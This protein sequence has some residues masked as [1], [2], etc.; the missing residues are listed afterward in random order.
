VPVDFG[1]A[2]SDYARHRAGFPAA[3]FD[4]L[5]RGGVV[6]PG[7]RLL[8]LGTGT[9]SL[10]RGFARRGLQVT[11]LDPARPLLDQARQ[12][13][14]AAGVAVAYVLARAESTGLA[15]ASFDVVSA[16]QCWHWFERARAAQEVRRLLRPGGRVVIAHFDWLPLPGNVVEA[17]ERLIRQHNPDWT[18]GGGTGL[19]PAWLADLALAG[20]AGLETFSFDHAVDYSRDAWRGRIRASAGIAASLAAAA[21]ARFDAEHEALLARDFPD[22]PL[23]VPHRCWAVIGVKP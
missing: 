22:D 2:A 20:F 10:A 15:D 19:H 21:V 14:D 12:L 11:G 13:D 9:G 7:Q 8:D 3:L 16:G 1:R 17:T 5:V 4:R 18:H 23:R 6:A